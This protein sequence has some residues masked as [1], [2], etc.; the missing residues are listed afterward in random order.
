MFAGRPRMQLCAA[1]LLV[2][3]AAESMAAVAPGTPI[4]V[5]TTRKRSG[6]LERYEG[7]LVGGSDSLVLVTVP[8][9]D[10]LRVGLEEIASLEVGSLEPAR[11]SVAGTL[12]GGVLGG[13]IFAAGSFIHLLAE[14]SSHEVKHPVA[15]L[16]LSTIA[17]TTLGAWIGG[18]RTGKRWV[19]REVTMSELRAA[20]AGRSPSHE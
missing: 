8:V 18:E 2:A 1:L 12:I 11:R 5:T 19:W 7:Q 4:R 13:A 9:G 10:T 16:T 14:A 6:S 17:G 15:I 3:T 20:D